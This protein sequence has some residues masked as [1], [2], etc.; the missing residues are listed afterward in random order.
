MNLSP[1]HKYLLY[2][3]KGKRELTTF[4][5]E[6]L[7]ARMCFFAYRYISDKTTAEDIVQEVFLKFLNSTEAFSSLSAVKGFLYK[8][9]RN[10]CLNLLKHKA[11]KER[12]LSQQKKIQTEVAP[13]FVE[14]IVS[15]EVTGELMDAI[16]QL[17]P[18]CRKIFKLSY[19]DEMSNAEIAVALAL[20]VQTVKN[21]KSR[22]Y[23]ILRGVLKN[24]IMSVLSFLQ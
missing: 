3:G 16:N 8:V 14:S 24:K 6:L 11:V 18:E 21:Q 22:G 17:P 5:F 23:A 1:E 10:D 4:L 20:S 15:A 13:D 19:I 2:E 12:Y 9:V 7:Y